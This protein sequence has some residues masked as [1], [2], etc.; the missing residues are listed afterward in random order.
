MAPSRHNARYFSSNN[1]NGTEP[2]WDDYHSGALPPV[3]GNDWRSESRS[4][5]DPPFQQSFR[6]GQHGPNHPTSLPNGFSLSRPPRSHPTPQNRHGNDASSSEG[7]AST[8]SANYKLDRSGHSDEDEDDGWDFVRKGRRFVRNGRI[9]KRVKVD[10]VNVHTKLFC[11]VCQLTFRNLNE[12]V[13]HEMSKDHVSQC[14]RNSASATRRFHTIHRASQQGSAQPIDYYRNGPGPRE[15]SSYASEDT[16]ITP[17]TKYSSKEDDIIV[18]P[19]I[20]LQPVNAVAATKEID[21]LIK[22]GTKFISASGLDTNVPQSFKTW[23][24]RS[25]KAVEAKIAA[26]EVDPVER[27]FVHREVLYTLSREIRSSTIYRSDWRHAELATGEIMKPRLAMERTYT[28]E[29]IEI[30]EARYRENQLQAQM[31]HQFGTPGLSLSKSTDDIVVSLPSSPTSGSKKN[32]K[33]SD[34]TSQ[35][36]VSGTDVSKDAI[37]CNDDKTIPCLFLNGLS[38]RCRLLSLASHAVPEELVIR[39]HKSRSML[40]DDKEAKG[41]RKDLSPLLCKYSSAVD[42]MKS[43]KIDGAKLM[44]DLNTVVDGLYEADTRHSVA[45]AAL[46]MLVPLAIDTRQYPE[47]AKASH[48]LMKVFD[49]RGFGEK[50]Y[51]LI[52]CWLLS[53]LHYGVA[54]PS[55]GVSFTSSPIFLTTMLRYLP[56]GSLHSPVVAEALEALAAVCTNHWINFLRYFKD[57]QAHSLS[58]GQTAALC[59]PLVP[60]MRERAMLTMF[61]EGHNGYSPFSVPGQLGVGEVA[62]ILLYSMGDEPEGAAEVRTLL[63]EMSE[64]LV[65]RGNSKNDRFALIL[66]EDIVG[67]IRDNDIVNIPL[68]LRL[69]GDNF[70]LVK[71]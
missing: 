7:F 21:A 68:L 34:S 57:P 48:R 6:S 64:K 63:E 54:N 65:V 55:N 9:A 56:C 58:E 50:D 53:L 70:Q 67:R 20:P 26:K 69:N 2:H 27:S 25:L 43:P 66:C 47:A 32:R 1:T 44:G 4:P 5:S 59:L 13:A 17:A 15:S 12:K 35:P 41:I 14:E 51:P 37:L 45:T 16:D 23:A 22:E 11:A 10:E 29:E 3:P 71:K 61:R 60:V 38:E 8:R 46:E 24:E 40:S 36:I 62:R 52:A 33:G 30:M 42:L 39:H 28:L 18:P 49:H 19:A 31:L